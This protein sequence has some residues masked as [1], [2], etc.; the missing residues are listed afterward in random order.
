MGKGDKRKTRL[1]KTSGGG[2]FIGFGAFA[3]SSSSSTLIVAGAAPVTLDATTLNTTTTPTKDSLSSPFLLSPPSNNNNNNNTSTSTSTNSLTLSPVY[4]GK[5]S[6]LSVLFPRIG[7]KRDATTKTKALQDLTEFFASGGH[8]NTVAAAA[9]GTGDA[10]RAHKKKTLVDALSHFLYLYHS[11]LYYDINSSVRAAALICLQQAHTVVPKAWQILTTEQ[12]PELLGMMYCAQADPAAHEVRMAATVLCQSLLS[13]LSSSSS[14]SSSVEEIVLEDHGQDQKAAFANGIWLY[15][16]RMVSYGRPKVLY[17]AVFAR[18]KNNATAVN[19]GV[20]GT[21]ATATSSSSQVGSSKKDGSK[22]DKS[23]G[24]TTTTKSGTSSSDLSEAQVDQMEERYERIVGAAIEGLQMW[25]R[26]HHSTTIA[27]TTTTTSTKNLSISEQPQEDNNNNNNNNSQG[28]IEYYEETLRMVWKNMGS[29]KPSLRRKTYALI[30]AC[31][32]IAPSS[33]L[34]SQEES[35]SSSSSSLIDPAKVGALLAQCLS[36]EKE[37][38]NQATLLETLLAFVAFLPKEQRHDTFQKLFAKPVKK[39]WKRACHGASASQ[40]APTVLPLIAITAPPPPT[41]ATTNAP[42]DNNIELQL[43]LLTSVWEGRTTVKATADVLE[44][45]AAVAESATF[46]LLKQAEAPVQENDDHRP[47][48]DQDLQATAANTATTKLTKTIEGVAHC[49]LEVLGVYLSTTPTGVAQRVH[50]R[51]CKAMARDLVQLDHASHRDTSAMGHIRDWFWGPT[52]IY[53]ILVDGAVVHEV[54]VDQKKASVHD[55]NLASWLLEL[56]TRRNE[57]Q[58]QQQQTLATSTSVSTEN[59]ALVSHVAPVLRHKFHSQLATYQGA[60]GLVPTL[61]TY[62]LWISIFRLVGVDQLFK[63]EEPQDEPSMAAITTSVEKFIMNDVL[64]WMIIH[65]SSLSEQA[66]E[67]LAKQDFTLLRLCEE[68]SATRH[69][70]ES[71]LRELVAAKCDLSLLTAGLEILLDNGVTVEDIQCKTLENLTIQVAQESAV[72]MD[73]PAADDDSEEVEALLEEYHKT[74]DFLQL[75]VGLGTLETTGMLVHQEV[76]NAWVDC[77]CPAVNENSKSHLRRI[78]GPNPVLDTLIFFIREHAKDADSLSEDQIHRV[79]LESWRQGGDLWR[80]TSVGLLQANPKLRV[81]I[82][83]LASMELQAILTKVDLDVAQV[84]LVWAERAARLLEVCQLGQSSIL[85]NEGSPLPSLKLVGFGN[86]KSWRTWTLEFQGG[87]SALAQRCFMNLMD[88]I[89]TTAD[90]L[91]LFQ[92]TDGVDTAEL[93][94]TILMALSGAGDDVLGA[95]SARRRNDASARLLNVLGAK[96]NL[97]FVL[98]DCWCRKA[99]DMLAILMG[100]ENSEKQLIGRGIAILSQL[101]ELLFPR[102]VPSGNR[103][104]YLK[105]EMLEA[106]KVQEGDTV[107]YILN[108]DLLSEREM[109]KIVKVHDDV[110]TDLYFTI[111]LL[112]RDDQEPERQT[113]VDRLRREPSPRSITNNEV[114]PEEMDGVAVNDVSSEEK[115]KRQ[116]L[117]QIIL[118]KLVRPFS[119]KWKLLEFEL[120]NVIVTQCGILGQRG[121]GS[122]HYEV[123]R[124]L[125][126]KQAQLKAL[127]DSAE[128]EGL[129]PAMLWQLA[130]ALGYGCNTPSSRWNM[131]LLA[132]DP[133]D[134]VSAIVRHYNDVDAG[135]NVELD[136]SVAAWLTV[137]I[138]VLTDGEL[139]DQ[140]M[141]LLFRLSASLFEASAGKEPVFDVNDFVALRAM[142]SA[143]LSSHHVDPGESMVQEDEAEALVGLVKAFASKWENRR[144]SVSSHGFD[145]DLPAWRSFP[146][147]KFVVDSSLNRRRAL[148]GAAVRRCANDVVCAMLSDSKRWHSLLFLNSFASAGIPLLDDQESAI[149]GGTAKRLA[150]WCNGLTEQEADE[151]EDD[152]KVAAQWLPEQLMNNVESWNDAAAES[153][154]VND[155]AATN[156]MVSWLAVLRIIDIAA[157]KDPVNRPSLTSYVNKCQAVGTALNTALSYATIGNDRKAKVEGLIDSEEIWKDEGA[158]ELTKLASLVV[159]RTVEVF[160]ALAKSWWEIECPKYVAQPVRDFVETRVAPEILRRE[161]ER[162]TQA[163]SFGDMSVKGSTVSREVTAMYIQDDF[164]LTVVIRLPLSFPFRSAEVDCSKTLGVP[165]TRWKRWSLQITQMLNNQGGTL[166]DALMLWKENVDKEFEGVE[167]CPICYSVLHV[168]CHKLPD[169]ECKTCHNRFHFDCLTQWFKNSGKSVCVICQQPWSGTRVT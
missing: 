43:S 93:V 103:V 92:N 60:S 167:P 100:Q 137:S 73:H 117:V 56:Q 135:S 99:I 59:V 15:V 9:G 81:S 155:V 6:Q 153:D 114:G 143:Q 105:E 123:F 1:N 54:A 76:I 30:G 32:Q 26:Q 53:S 75:C 98:V 11:K 144:E 39:Q 128:N 71:V 160:P 29:P 95:D 5:D 165:Q 102:V 65:T 55:N 46:V 120:L 94:V 51:L 7:Q 162:I 18:H 112:D 101:V 91:A 126:S 133:A 35:L 146:Y 119:E 84:S 142:C 74:V 13:S 134:S 58:Q 147:F 64:R 159:F 109:V 85:G 89:H 156:Q 108:K 34:S 41:A 33:S 131:A 79:L 129:I 47:T 132:F 17:D 19:I 116:D 37:P 80:D 145:E 69:H 149:N 150:I 24:S 164:T 154:H 52:G 138:S 125:T 169:M 72:G 166:Q 40:W 110:P 148:V 21:S 104:T 106:T 44:I 118:Q 127:F 77:A 25:I 121:L 61:V 31:C 82:I 68:N 136:R 161:L 90:R 66:D 115:A 23:T 2:E 111:K 36:T 20:G 48:T 63:E 38:V 168:K 163:P 16:R 70:W 124:L 152:V 45:A 12:Q 87:L 22:N 113:V 141:S 27:T 83:Q 96:D 140:A 130:F 14:S 42:V 62:Q 10:T 97:G 4:V 88:Q 78:Q 3:S 157:T 86:L 49:W 158:L 139:R 50:K 151:L 8:S 122:I 28:S 107:W 67:T 57:Q